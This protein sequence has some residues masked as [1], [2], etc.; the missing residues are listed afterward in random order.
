MV[1]LRQVTLREPAVVPLPFGRVALLGTTLNMCKPRDPKP[2][3][4]CLHLA[5]HWQKLVPS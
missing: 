4:L 2:F 1:V 3:R 5:A